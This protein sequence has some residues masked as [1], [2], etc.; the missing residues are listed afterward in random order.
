MFIDLIL[1][2]NKVFIGKIRQDIFDMLKFMLIIEI[3]LMH[4]ES[5]LF[6]YDSL[7][8]TY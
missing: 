7:F 5:V 6:L 4:T 1:R 8:G 3:L 2:L